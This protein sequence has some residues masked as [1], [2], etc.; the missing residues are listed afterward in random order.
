[1]I[2]IH[3]ILD[4]GIKGTFLVSEHHSFYCIIQRPGWMKTQEYLISYLSL[5]I[6]SVIYD[7]ELEINSPRVDFS[8]LVLHSLVHLYHCHPSSYFGIKVKSQSLTMLTFVASSFALF[9]TSFASFA[10]CIYF[11][12]HFISKINWTWIFYIWICISNIRFVFF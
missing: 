7:W 4:W 5:K 8:Q 1:M 9:Q 10:F 2:F 6:K 12:C 11:P 3:L